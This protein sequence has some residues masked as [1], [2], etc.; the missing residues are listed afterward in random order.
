[1]TGAKRYSENNLQQLIA[2]KVGRKMKKFNNKNVKNVEMTVALT[3]G[4][5]AVKVR[6]GGN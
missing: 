6:G 3:D 4:E 2:L 1:M 5:A